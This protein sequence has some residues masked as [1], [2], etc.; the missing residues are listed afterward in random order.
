MS[1]AMTLEGI[2]G[3]G[4]NQDDRKILRSLFDAEPRPVSA[5]SLALCLGVP[6][7]TVMNV[8]EPTL[9]RLGFV[10]IGTGGRRLTDKG[11]QH[12]EPVARQSA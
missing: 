3:E 1:V 5:R 12:I 11:R 4:L 6:T 7:E 8:L 9:V 2:D 10:T